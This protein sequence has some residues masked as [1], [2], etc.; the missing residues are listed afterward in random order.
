MRFFDSHAHYWDS[1]FEEELGKEETDKLL[2][3]LLAG[4]VPRIVNVATSPETAR[5]TVAQAQRYEG[6]LTALGIHPSDCQSL[7]S[8]DDALLSIEEMLKDPKS[9]AVAL[10]EIGLDYH[11]EDTQKE[12]QQLYFREQLKMAERLSLPV[13]IHD[14][15]A[16]GDVLK[17]LSEFP[18]VSGI[19]HSYSG[20]AEMAKELIAHGYYISFSGTVTFKNAERVRKVAAALPPDRLL[21]ETDCPYLSPDPYRG[22]LNHSGRLPFTLSALSSAVGIPTEEYAKTVYQNTLSAY[23]L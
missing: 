17:I 21:I 9:K 10:G 8:M 3:S 4:E 6:M 18:S 11:Y 23:R 19:L 12:K 13:V 2:S 1:R 20:S 22:R 14:R 15:D 7:S 16:H 5:L